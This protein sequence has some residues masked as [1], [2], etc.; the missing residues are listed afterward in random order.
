MDL[1]RLDDQG[2]LFLSPDV[3]DWDLLMAEGISAVIDM[4]GGIDV[5]MPEIPNQILYVYFPFSDALLPD[6]AK[7]HAI[8]QLGATII[9][10]GHKLL[11][12]CGLGF[13]RSALMAG[14][15]LRYLGLSGAE[16]LDL[17][18]RRRPGALYNQ[19]YA[20]YLLSCDLESSAFSGK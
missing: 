11:S 6:L 7:L 8:A 1:V 4:D 9:N 13:N 18:R 3:D 15:I 12:H 17:L 2:R 5:G 10:S 16:S 19:C 14:L 20:D